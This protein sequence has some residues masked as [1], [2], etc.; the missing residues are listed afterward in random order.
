MVQAQSPLTIVANR[1]TWV[2][3]TSAKASRSVSHSSG[4][5]SAT[6]DTGQWCW[7]S[8]IP[9]IGPLTGV[10]G[11]GV[12]GLGQCVGDPID[13]GF[14]VVGSLGYSRQDGV[15]AASREGPY[16]VVAADFAELTHGRDGQVVVGVP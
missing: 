3:S 5:S 13:S 2:P 11:C 9:W 7:Q 6:C 1:C 4:N 15:D 8:C 12:T 10:V 16:G 14:N